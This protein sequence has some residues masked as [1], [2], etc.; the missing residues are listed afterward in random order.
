MALRSRPLWK[1]VPLCVAVEPV[2]WA[3]VSA[4]NP[5]IPKG[6]IS[7]TVNDLRLLFDYSYWANERLFRVIL[8]LTPEEFTRSV[9]G[10]YGSVRNTLVHVLSTEWGWLDRCGGPERGP[11]LEVDDY[12]TVAS[13]IEAWRR[14][15]AY[16]RGFLDGL[17]DQDLARNVEYRG[18]GGEKRFMPLGELLHHA[19]NHAVHHRGQVVLLLRELGHAPGNMDLLFYYADRRGIV[20]W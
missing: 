19:A 13:L 11:R 1:W 9:A 4:L 7:M 8:Q 14:I 10:S 15:E 16:M 2:H 20:A 3:A 6:S 5:A 12:P 18:A 17:K